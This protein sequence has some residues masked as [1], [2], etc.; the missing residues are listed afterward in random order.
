MFELLVYPTGLF[1]VCYN[2]WGCPKVKLN[3]HLESTLTK[4]E[5]SR[6]RHIYIAMGNIA[7]RS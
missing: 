3:G 4:F 5:Y 7:K 6:A 1:S 2:M